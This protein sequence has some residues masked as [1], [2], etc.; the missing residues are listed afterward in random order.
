MRI[1]IDKDFYENDWEFN[2]FDRALLK[3]YNIYLC[4][5]FYK[6]DLTNN[7]FCIGP[8]GFCK[9]IQKNSDY[10]PCCWPSLF[11]NYDCL[12]YYP[13]LGELLL[14][15]DYRI[16]PFGD[17]LRLK[18]SIFNQSKRIFIRPT[19][20]T[21]IFCG[22]DVSYNRLESDLISLGAE[23]LP[24][25]TTCLIA[26]Y[27][28]I[29]KEWRCVVSDRVVDYC[30]YRVNGDCE[31]FKEANEEVV[32]LAE[33]VIKL[34]RP[35]P[36]FTIDIALVGNEYKVLEINGFSCAGWYCCDKE[37]ILEELKIQYERQRT[38]TIIDMG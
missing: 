1:L 4:H 36:M 15:S 16:L 24:L 33:S 20:G 31:E 35:D 30:V 17:I 8:I 7:Y 28:E 11:S 21:K 14:N 26:P 37:K 22:G 6:L 38:Q 29:E 18:D 3:K 10:D 9:Y 32:K 34:Y 23:N 25:N 19:S 2:D 27:Q 12:N 5:K 13:K